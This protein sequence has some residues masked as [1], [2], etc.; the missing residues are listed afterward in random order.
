MP[1]GYR[2]VAMQNLGGKK[3]V[4]VEESRRM[5]KVYRQNINVKEGRQLGLSATSQFV[6]VE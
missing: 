1:D 3:K 6:A 2:S 5:K 4:V